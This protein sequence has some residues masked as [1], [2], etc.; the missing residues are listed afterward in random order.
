MAI[1]G[2]GCGV[3]ILIAAMLERHVISAPS[4]ARPILRILCFAI[5]VGCIA[6]AATL[7]LRACFEV[8]EYG[9]KL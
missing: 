4:W 5:Y 9:V 6:A 2:T 7:F 3:A 1:S 8:L